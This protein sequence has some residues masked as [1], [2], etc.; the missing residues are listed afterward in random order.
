MS[1]EIP[2]FFSTDDNYVPYLDVAIASLV[3]NASK[4]HNYR[5]IVLTTGISSE[6]AFKLKQNECDC[7]V[8]DIIDI[9]DK[10]ENI[11]SLFKNIYHFSVVTYYR[12][13]I[14]SLFLSMIR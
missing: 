3:A 7:F 4:D 10:L 13:F 2:I 12:L 14:A 6:N 9:S 1:R 8:I 11:R 5:I